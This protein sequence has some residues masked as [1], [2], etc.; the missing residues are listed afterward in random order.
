MASFS[1]RTFVGLTFCPA[2]DS[3][4][5]YRLSEN[6]GEQSWRNILKSL[7]KQQSGSDS[8]LRN[9]RVPFALPLRP[10]AACRVQQTYVD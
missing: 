1:A 7:M 4:T 6:E 3:L 9:Q 8:V 10:K 5:G 2:F